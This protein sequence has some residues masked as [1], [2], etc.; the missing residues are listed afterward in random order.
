MGRRWDNR[1]GFMYFFA[2]TPFIVFINAFL[3]SV[4]KDDEPPSLSVSIIKEGCLGPLPVKALLR[5]GT[6]VP[7]LPDGARH[8]G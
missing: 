5:N 2:P 8:K 7:L 1:F 3:C 6:P 4:T